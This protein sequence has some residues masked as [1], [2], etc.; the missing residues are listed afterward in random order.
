LAHDIETCWDPEE[1]DGGGEVVRLL[2]TDPEYQRLALYFRY[3]TLATMVPAYFTRTTI[4]TIFQECCNHCNKLGSYFE[5][6]MFS[7]VLDLLVD[8]SKDETGV[9]WMWWDQHGRMEYWCRALIHD[10]L[11]TGRSTTLLIMYILPLWVHCIGLE[12][13][14]FVF[15]RAKLELLYESW[16]RW[17]APRWMV[18]PNSWEVESRSIPLM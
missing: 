8:S 12:A 6:K 9:Q 14:K 11:F 15:R 2:T 13:G 7:M 1:A 4:S 17:V 16:K 10:P 18:I 3:C 5:R